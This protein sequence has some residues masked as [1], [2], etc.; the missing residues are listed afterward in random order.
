LDDNTSENSGE[1]SESLLDRVAGIT[2]DQWEYL[3]NLIKNGFY[4]QAIREVL[5]LL[6]I[7]YELSEG[8]I[9]VF[10]EY[11]IVFDPT[12]D[13]SFTDLSIENGELGMEIKIGT[14]ATDSPQELLGTIFH[15]F[16]HV[17]QML[18]HWYTMPEGL[19]EKEQ[20]AYLNSFFRSDEV[21]AHIV[22]AGL[23]LHMGEF[24]LYIKEMSLA[25]E[26]NSGWHG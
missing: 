9:Y 25:F 16:F 2:E 23:Y 21:Q 13:Y 6:G 14:G 8:G 19:S 3:Y 17:L 11:L 12:H 22:T 7:P 5:D 20:I 1:S 24:W 15:E 26:Y 4:K 18:E 10:G